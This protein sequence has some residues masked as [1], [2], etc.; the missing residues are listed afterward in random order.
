MKKGAS[1][2]TVKSDDFRFEELDEDFKF[3]GDIREEDLL[4]LDDDDDDDLGGS[5]EEDYY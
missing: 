3:E 4:I 2:N 1:K 5:Y